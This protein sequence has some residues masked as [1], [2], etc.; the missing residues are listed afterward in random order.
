[1]YRKTMAD[2]GVELAS[3]KPTE[4][5]MRK[6]S[7]TRSSPLYPAAPLGP[8]GIDGDIGNKRPLR[9]P[10]ATITSW[11]GSR[12][13]DDGGLFSH[14]AAGETVAGAVSVG[15]S[16]AADYSAA[17]PLAGLASATDAAESRPRQR[18]VSLSDG[19]RII[20]AT[21]D[22]IDPTELG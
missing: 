16:R 22:Q 18:T 3:A 13:I 12:D 14:P 2:T 4:P 19:T 1:L 11:S 17:H 21:A 8:S 7:T 9:I 15:G 6:P 10:G 20:F 5:G